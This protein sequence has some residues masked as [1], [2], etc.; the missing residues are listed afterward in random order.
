MGTERML[1]WVIGAAT[2]VLERPF[3]EESSPEERELR[4]RQ[5]RSIL[6][7]TTGTINNL[8]ARVRAKDPLKVDR[9]LTSIR[10]VEARLQGIRIPT[11]TSWASISWT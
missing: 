2:R 3:G 8:V 6:D 10:E 11:R 7:A 4:T 5:N 9:Y 1:W